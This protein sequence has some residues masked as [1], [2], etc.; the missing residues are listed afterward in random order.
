MSSKLTRAGV[1]CAAA[2]EDDSDYAGAAATERDLTDAGGR[3][4]KVGDRNPDV[5][6]DARRP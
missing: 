5:R 6:R 1:R 2:T 3:L 4:V